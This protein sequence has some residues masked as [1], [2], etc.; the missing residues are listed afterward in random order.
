[1]NKQRPDARSSFPD[2]AILIRFQSYR[3]AWIHFSVF[4]LSSFIYSSHS[5]ELE[6]RF[7][8]PAA[9][10]SRV[11]RGLVGFAATLSIKFVLMNV[12]LRSVTY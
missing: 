1:M 6:V 12:G 8:L 7:C 11:K 5:V 9:A 2:V 3:S 10:S 4:I